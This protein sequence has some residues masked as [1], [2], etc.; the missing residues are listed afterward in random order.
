MVQLA[1]LK[2]E[3][4]L[5]TLFSLSTLSL[6]YST[7]TMPLAYQGKLAIIHLTL[8]STPSPTSS[9]LEPFPILEPTFAPIVLL[10]NNLFQKFIW[11]YIKKIRNQVPIAPIAKTREEILYNVV[12]SYN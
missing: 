9:G 3:E 11:M 7:I 8:G 10:I 2:G 12:K 5:P 1:H 4:V 6:L